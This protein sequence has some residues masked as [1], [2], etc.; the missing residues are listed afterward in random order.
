MLTVHFTVIDDW[1]M[2]SFTFVDM[3]TYFGQIRYL[4]LQD[5]ILFYLEGGDGPF[6]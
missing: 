3:H 5:R 4:R 2:T 6:L 1:C